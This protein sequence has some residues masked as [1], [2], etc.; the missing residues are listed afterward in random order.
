MSASSEVN[1]SAILEGSDLEKARARERL[2]VVHAVLELLLAFAVFLVFVPGGLSPWLRD[3]TG[4]DA[5]FLARVGYMLAFLV[6]MGLIELP[7]SVYFDY[8]MGKRFG[9]LKQSFAGWL[10]DGLK[11]GAI[12]GLISGLLLLGLYAIFQAFPNLWFPLA[13]LLVSLFF[14]VLLVLQPRL[15]RLRFKSAPL[16]HPE[17]EARV[18]ALFQRAN[19][20]LVR[21]SKWL[22]GEKTKQGNAALSPVGAGSEVLISDTLLERVSLD[23]IE[24]VL[25]HELGHK[26]HKDIYKLLAAS[27]LQFAVMIALAYLALSSVG[28]QF[29]LRGPVDIATLPVLVFVFSVVGA[30]FSLVTNAITRSIEYAADRYALEQTRNLPA[31]EETFRI[32]AKDNLSDPD[33]PDWVE[34]WLH[35]HPSIEKRMRAARAWAAQQA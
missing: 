17:L 20:P 30:L 29:G 5:N 32:L 3:A 28:F 23:G 8:V 27:W 11:E 2:K 9:L 35:N 19:V 25:A 31:C 21:V 24:V 16:E 7:F 1:S 6:I 12:G 10:V 34:F 15:A 14:A 33:P 4:G 18:S 13:M 22:F 26:V